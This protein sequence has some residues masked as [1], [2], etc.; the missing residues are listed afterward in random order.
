MYFINAEDFKE[1]CAE[2]N[3]IG[4]AV[5]Q[6]AELRHSYFR[7]LLGLTLN[8]L[9]FK[10]KVVVLERSVRATE[11]NMFNESVVK[12]HVYENEKLDMLFEV[13]KT[14]AKRIFIACLS[15]FES[16]V[17]VLYGP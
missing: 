7:H 16:R 11:V 6:R 1:L 15:E 12:H 10:M 14:K 3:E 17:A 4:N 13:A 8:D 2:N 9:Y 5:L